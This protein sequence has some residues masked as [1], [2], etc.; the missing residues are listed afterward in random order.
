M[1]RKLLLQLAQGWLFTI[2]NRWNLNPNLF[3][4]CVYD[5]IELGGLNWLKTLYLHLNP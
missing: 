2:D 5:G 3:L 1:Q 4:F